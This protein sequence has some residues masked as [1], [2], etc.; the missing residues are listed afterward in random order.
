[1]SPGPGEG[2]FLDRIQASR[3]ALRKVQ[4][5]LARMA[6][7]AEQRKALIDAMSRLVMPGEQ[8]QLMTDMIDAFGPPLAQIEALQ[9]ELAEQRA[10]VDRMHDRLTVMEASVERLRLAAE[11]LVALQEPWVRMAETLT[12]QSRSADD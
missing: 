4:Q 11:S 5:S 3:D 2:D 6:M 1:M 9:A 7:P 10:E 12:G 8:L